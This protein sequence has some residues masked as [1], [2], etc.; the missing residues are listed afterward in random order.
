MIDLYKIE[1]L[2]SLSERLKT[3]SKM[4]G[5]FCKGLKITSN[6]VFLKEVPHFK[7]FK[8]VH[9]NIIFIHRVKNLIR[10]VENSI[11]EI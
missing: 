7:F 4:N 3:V 1:H 10:I 5:L 8:Q 9:H 6:L 11:M 2:K